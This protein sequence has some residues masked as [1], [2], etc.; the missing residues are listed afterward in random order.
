LAAGAQDI[1]ALGMIIYRV[2]VG[3]N[4]PFRGRSEGEVRRGWL[5]ADVGGFLLLAL[6]S[7]Q[8]D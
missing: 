1:W 8:G 3:H 7:Q 2:E 6:F 5:L 4:Y